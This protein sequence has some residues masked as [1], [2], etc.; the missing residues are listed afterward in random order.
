LVATVCQNC[1]EESSEL[2]S[3]CFVRESHDT[4]SRVD[5]KAVVR[6]GT[7]DRKTTTGR[8]FEGVGLADVFVFDSDDRTGSHRACNDYSGTR[9]ERPEFSPSFKR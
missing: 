7:V 8:E 1:T 3:R 6:V 4:D 9:S 5:R 2:N